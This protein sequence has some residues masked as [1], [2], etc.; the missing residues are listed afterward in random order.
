M[1]LYEDAQSSVAAASGTSASFE[2]SVGVHQGSALSPLLFNLVMEE[3]TK[4]H[5]RGVPWDMLY[6]DDLVL[7]VESKE[8]VQEQF[9]RW[10]S[11][12]ESEGLKVNLGKTKTLVTGK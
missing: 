9:N 4:E 5:R 10:M 7:T 8:E 2:I 3:A 12:M 6:A 11:A 1:A